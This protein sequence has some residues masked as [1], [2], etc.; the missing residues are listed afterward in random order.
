[1]YDRCHFVTGTTQLAFFAVQR[2]GTATLVTF[3]ASA[4]KTKTYRDTNID[5]A[6]VVPTKLFKFVG[7]SIAFCSENEDHLNNSLDRNKI[8]NGGYFTFRIVDKDILHLPMIAI[9]EVNPIIF[10]TAPTGCA[11]G[12]YQGIYRFP[13]PITLNPYENFSVTLDFDTSI[14]VTSAHDIYVIMHAFMRRPT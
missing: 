3:A 12:L 6:N 7:M 13:V 5:N 10:G 1:M 14:T 2:G 8:R 9:P 11:V 4:A